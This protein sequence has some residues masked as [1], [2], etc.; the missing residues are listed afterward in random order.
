ML[1]GASLK[2]RLS[3]PVITAGRITEIK[4]DFPS[5]SVQNDTH[6]LLLPAAYA[7]SS[8]SPGNIKIAHLS[9]A[10]TRW[11][12][13]PQVNIPSSLTEQCFTKSKVLFFYTGKKKN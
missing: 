13:V 2:D 3:T 10:F 4:G 11:S 1:Y 12:L 8:S 6:Q 9:L 5:S 7:Q